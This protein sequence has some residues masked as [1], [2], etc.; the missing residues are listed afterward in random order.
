MR[1]IL[2]L[3][4]ILCLAFTVTSCKKRKARKTLQGTWEIIFYDGYF[5]NTCS[6][7][8]DNL[9]EYSD[10]GF[11]TLTFENKNYTMNLDIDY[12]SGGSLECY[13]LEEYVSSGTFNVKDHTRDLV[14]INRYEVIIGSRTWI[15]EFEGEFS[16]TEKADGSQ[17]RI[18][19]D[20]D[21][22]NRGDINLYLQRIN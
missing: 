7:E 16:T 13:E 17:D 11:G 20:S 15:C 19:L 5:D 4:L 2:T 21:L 12:V 14:V 22:T 3:A 6:G 8:I 18:R 9:Y 10:D 1:R